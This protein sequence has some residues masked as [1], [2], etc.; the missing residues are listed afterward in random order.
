M[1]AIGGR[2]KLA[3]QVVDVVGRILTLVQ[4]GGWTEVGRVEVEAWLTL[5][6]QHSALRHSALVMKAA[7]ATKSLL[8]ELS[9][10]KTLKF[11]FI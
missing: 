9:I 3:L 5:H 1:V 4:K 8:L 11:Y 2:K 6:G 10:I 7:L